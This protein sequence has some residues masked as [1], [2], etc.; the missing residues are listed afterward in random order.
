MEWFPTNFKAMVAVECL[1]LKLKGSPT[2]CCL[3]GIIRTA[4]L[5]PRPKRT[6]AC[7]V[8]GSLHHRENHAF[9]KTTTSVRN[10]PTFT[11][12]ERIP[13]MN[14]L[15]PV[16]FIFPRFCPFFLAE[17]PHFR[18]LSPSQTS[19]ERCQFR[20]TTSCSC[21]S[22]R[23]KSESSRRLRRCFGENSIVRRCEKVKL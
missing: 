16:C 3:P 18:I 4:S 13:S 11:K 1:R 14:P 19:W 23:P 20:A 5:F 8:A 17:F 12:T 9:F 6:N 21:R 7:V 10:A 22:E 2:S 15:Q